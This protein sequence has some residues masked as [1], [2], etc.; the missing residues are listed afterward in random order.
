MKLKAPPRQRKQNSPKVRAKLIRIG[1]SR[2]IRLPKAMIE[3]AGLA[4]KVEIVVDRGSIIIR[5]APKK[6]LHAEWEEQFNRAIAKYGP[7]EPMDPDWEYM[8]N[9]FDEKE[10]T[11]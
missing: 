2:G 7:A 11:W 10:W 9:E 4:D 5:P 1:N 8:P 6:D 3:Q